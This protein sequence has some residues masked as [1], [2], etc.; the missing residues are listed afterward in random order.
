MQV[1]DMDELLCPRKREGGGYSSMPP[2]SITNINIQSIEMSVR[3]IIKTS[4]LWTV[5]KKSPVSTP[6]QGCEQWLTL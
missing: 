4:W 6:N 3:G 5:E 1:N 2:H